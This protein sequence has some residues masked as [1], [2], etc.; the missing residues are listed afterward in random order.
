M[1]PFEKFY[2]ISGHYRHYFSTSRKLTF[3]LGTDFLYITHTDTISQQNNFYFLGG[4]TP[5]TIRS[6][7]LAG[8]HPGEIRVKRMGEVMAQADYELFPAFHLELLANLAVI[9]EASE[10]KGYSFISG[11]GLSVGY[12]SIFGPLRA[13]IMNG[14]YGKEKYFSSIKAFISLGYNF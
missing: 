13:G 2:T 6:I 12:S 1:P 7:P 14:I 8:F 5:V 4:M 10:N 9:R 3:G 11:Y